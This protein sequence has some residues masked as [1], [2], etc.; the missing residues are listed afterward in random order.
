MP[1]FIKLAVSRPPHIFDFRVS[2]QPVAGPCIFRLC[3]NEH[4]TSSARRICLRQSRLFKIVY[5][6]LYT[7]FSNTEH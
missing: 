3:F 1:T 7:Q 6:T 2:P 4:P 5:K